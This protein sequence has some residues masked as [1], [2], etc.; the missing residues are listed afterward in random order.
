MRIAIVQLANYHTEIMGAILQLFHSLYDEA[1]FEMYVPSDHNSY[2]S[3]HVKQLPS[4]T[5]NVHPNNMHEVRK[6]EYDLYIWLTSRECVGK[7]TSDN[8]RRKT[9]VVAH[10]PKEILPS[11][12]NIV[13]SHLTYRKVKSI[14]TIMPISI[15]KVNV[16]S[17]ISE[18]YPITVIIIGAND[19]SY[20]AKDFNALTRIINDIPSNIRIKILSRS[21][22]NI[23]SLLN[24]Y[25]QLIGRLDLPAN[26][27]IDEITNSHYIL[28]LFNHNSWYHK[29]RISVRCHYQSHMEN[30]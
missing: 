5:Y 27:F 13:L 15:P 1:Q 6:L 26:D 22:S 20:K 7:I 29:D 23:R 12:N 28:T 10:V 30:H 17:H 3:Y 8:E 14:Q 21:G 24:R 9:I 18:E 19:Y 16:I 4:L 25:P 2:L 11:V